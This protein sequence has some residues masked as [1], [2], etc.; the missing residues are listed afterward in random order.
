MMQRRAWLLPLSLGLAVA[1]L[2]GPASATAE[3]GTRNKRC[4]GTAYPRREFSY[5]TSVFRGELVFNLSRCY[6]RSAPFRAR[7]TIYRTT[8]AG[9][10]SITSIG[11]CARF[12]G[13]KIVRG[14]CHL[15]VILKHPRIERARYRVAVAFTLRDGSWRRL[16]RVF[17]KD[18]VSAGFVAS[19]EKY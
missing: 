4:R 9:T 17:A 2:L 11:R 7:A 15:G 19:C 1:L 8:A 13:E 14:K 6:R 16:P 18:C 5:T 12:P 10:E 3:E